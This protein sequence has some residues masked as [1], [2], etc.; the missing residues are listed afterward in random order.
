MMEMTDR[1]R[2]DLVYKGF[3]CAVITSVDMKTRS[4]KSK[5]GQ[6]S[7]EDGMRRFRDLQETCLEGGQ[8]YW[9][10]NPD[11]TM[12]PSLTLRENV[13]ISQRSVVK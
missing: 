2:R 9:C 5:P 10:N 6:A 11:R 12:S 4:K 8:D 1:K 13:Q 3:M 7:S